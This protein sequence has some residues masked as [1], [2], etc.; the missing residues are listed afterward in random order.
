M[1]ID[2]HNRIT[3]LTQVQVYTGVY[4]LAGASPV[5]DDTIAYNL[6][7]PTLSMI[8]GGAAEPLAVKRCFS[9]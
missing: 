2:R 6:T 4:Q 1:V 3:A 7:G 5:V 8:E 9:R